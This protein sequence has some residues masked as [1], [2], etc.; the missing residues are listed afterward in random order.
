M[1]GDG[2]P[3][4]FSR[5]KDTGIPD[6]QSWCHEITLA[7]RER[8]AQNFLTEIKNFAK[9]V[10]TYVKGF[11]EVSD[12]DR[13][14]LREIWESN[15][16]KFYSKCLAYSTSTNPRLDSD[17]NPI[18]IVPR[19][20]K[21]SA[22][23]LEIEIWINNFSSQEFTQVVEKTVAELQDHFKDGLEDRCQVGAAKAAEAAVGCSDRFAARIMHWATFRASE[24]QRFFYC[25]N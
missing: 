24:F 23:N 5:I 16:G 2:K 7:S 1:K 11:A 22:P 15:D 12:Q 3:A 14:V 20:V 6:L 25:S 13:D 4:C 9:S 18:G 8:S 21:V 19:L 10:G 17:G